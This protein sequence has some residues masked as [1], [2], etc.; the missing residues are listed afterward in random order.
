MNLRLRQ[1]VLPVL[2]LGLAAGSSMP[3]SAKPAAPAKPGATAAAKPSAA[4]A[5]ATFAGGCFWHVE[6]SFEQVKGVTS[7]VSGFSG[8]R[9]A[10]PTYEQVATRSTGHAEAVQVTYDP[11]VVSYAQLVDVFWH[12]IDPTDA[13]GQFCDRGDEYRTVAFYRTEEERRV[14]EESKRRIE[15]TAKLGAPIVTEV[16]RF[17]TFYPAEDYHQDF[18]KKN[19]VRYHGHSVGCGGKARLA[20]LWGKAAR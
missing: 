17:A 19:P 16:A 13:G 3:V 15:A 7:V 18:Y 5:V 1:L 12:T 14:I 11:K 2:T 6:H 9:T 10:N 20:K 4:T 8:G